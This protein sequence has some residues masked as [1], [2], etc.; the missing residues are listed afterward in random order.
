M[1]QFSAHNFVTSGCEHC[2]NRIEH[3][4]HRHSEYEFRIASTS[5]G[6]LFHKLSFNIRE[7]RWYCSC[8]AG[9]AATYVMQRQRV[10]KAYCKHVA[11]ALYMQEHS[12]WVMPSVF[13]LGKPGVIS[14]TP[15]ELFDEPED[16]PT[17]A[18]RKPRP[19][20]EDLMQVG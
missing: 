8:E 15:W 4:S 6:N 11:T 18:P 19:S 16:E 12:L 2:E 14:V 5:R 13:A 10:L 3:R 20:L 7:Q 9:Q 17:P 1:P